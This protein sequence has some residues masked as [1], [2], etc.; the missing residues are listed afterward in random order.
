MFV[1]PK[2]TILA[3]KFF[4]QIQRRIAQHALN[5]EGGDDEEGGDLQ[6]EKFISNQEIKGLCT[7]GILAEC[8][9]KHC[10]DDFMKT[11]CLSKKVAHH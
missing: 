8:H 11:K 1:R 10:R 3:Y 2:P 7:I 6:E 9:T 5:P 4:T